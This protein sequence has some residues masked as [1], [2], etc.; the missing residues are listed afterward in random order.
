M[1]EGGNVVKDSVD[2]NLDIDENAP[3]GARVYEEDDLLKLVTVRDSECVY[4]FDNCDFTF[5]EGTE[6]PY[7]NSTVH[8]AEWNEDKTFYIKCRD[9]FRNEDADCSIIVRP[10]RN[11]L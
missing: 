5:A 9:E 1:D 6:M 2:F 11:F 10:S 7:G 4:S 3:V 8:V